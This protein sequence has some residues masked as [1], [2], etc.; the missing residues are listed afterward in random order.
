MGETIAIGS[1]TEPLAT[2]AAALKDLEH[3]LTA[4]AARATHAL[5]EMHDQQACRTPEVPDAVVLIKPSP[6]GRRS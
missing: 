3:I 4:R 6:E 2:A 5:G 1:G